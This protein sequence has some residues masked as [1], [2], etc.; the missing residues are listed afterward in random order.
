MKILI[1][2][3]SEIIIKSK[4]VRKRYM[5]TLQHNL[6]VAIKKINQEIKVN[7]F[8]DKLEINWTLNTSNNI[9]DL[10]SRTPWIELFLIVEDFPLSSNQDNDTIFDNILEKTTSFYLEKIKN[11]TFVVRVKRSWSH[12]Y[13]STDVE[14]Y[15]WS[16]LLKILDEKWIQGKVDLKKPEITVKIEIKDNNLFIIK[17]TFQGIWGYPTWTQDKVLSL[18]SGW[19][20]SWVSTYSMIKRWC[21]VDFLFFNLWWKA[22]ELWVK[23]VSY[24]INTQFSH[25][26]Q[27]KIITIPFEKVVKEIVLKINNR[28]RWIVLKRFM[29]KIADKIAKEKWYYAL[30]K[31]DSLWQ[32]S[33]QTL[34]NLNVIDKASE[35]LTLRPLISFNKQEIIDISRKIWTYDYA[36]NMP[37]YCWVISDK[38]A[39]WAKLFQVLAEEE[40]FNTDLLDKAFDN[41][42]SIYT[43]E[44]LNEANLN[45]T[46]LNF[47]SFPNSSDIIIDIREELNFSETPLTLKTNQIINIPF[48]D[49]NFEFG[50]LDNNKTYLLYCDKWILSKLHYLYLKEKW[51]ENI[52]ILKLIKKD[53]ACNIKNNL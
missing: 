11:K 49:I 40:K 41:Q 3:F 32:V 36:I 21:K 17:Q 45:D 46:S 26:Y 33:S 37:E 30:V 35:T 9:I 15:V 23:Q 8:W 39:T 43:K 53:K 31:W 4:P 14:R 38:P 29:L 20:D 5:Q 44:I 1:K 25:W 47:V 7:L 16:G 13:K 19:F 24:F 2:P 6:Y 22:H 52:W 27:A 34:K 12:D 18:I 28:F 42:V 48:F 51:F 50:K 10:L